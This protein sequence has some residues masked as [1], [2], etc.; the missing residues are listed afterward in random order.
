MLPEAPK[1]YFALGVTFA[2]SGADERRPGILWKYNEK[3]NVYGHVERG[4][5]MQVGDVKR[6]KNEQ[7]LMILSQ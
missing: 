7:T 3:E 5:C 6:K 1:F 2:S 4:P